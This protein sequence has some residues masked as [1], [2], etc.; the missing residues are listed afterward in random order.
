MLHFWTGSKCALHWPLFLVCWTDLLPY[1]LAPKSVL[2]GLATRVGRIWLGEILALAT[3]QL[4][5]AWLAKLWIATPPTSFSFCLLFLS[6]L[7]QFLLLR[8]IEV[9][10][11]SWLAVLNTDGNEKTR[12]GLA[13]SGRS[14]SSVFKIIQVFSLANPFTSAHK[15]IQPLIALNVYAKDPSGDAADYLTDLYRVIKL[16]I[17]KEL[18]EKPTRLWQGQKTRHLCEF[19]YRNTHLFSG[20]R[21]IKKIFPN[22]KKDFMQMDY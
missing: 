11:T 19:Q 7:F 9:N 12:A 18:G 4:F 14:S 5:S 10:L 3:L 17:S 8:N 16:D 6:T 13:S 1:S 20:M 2:L 15:V 21:H 22:F